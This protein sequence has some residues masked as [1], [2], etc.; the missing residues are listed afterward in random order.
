M[1]G[2]TN[3]QPRR[4]KMTTVKM[5]LCLLT[6]A[7][8]SAVA[9]AINQDSGIA[10][11]QFFA[12]NPPDLL[13]VIN[14]PASLKSVPVP[15]PRNLARYI[16]D[17][18]AAIAL[19]KALFWDM[20][21]GSDGQA[22]GSCHFHAFADSRSK[23]QL[24]PGFRAVP[25]DNTFSKFG[26][27][28]GGPN[29]Q[30]K[31]S[32]YPFHRLADPNNQDSVVLFDTNDITS[33]A[34]VFNFAF[35]GIAP[36]NTVGNETDQGTIASPDPVFNVNG[37]NVR[38]VEP[39]NTPT[40]INAVFN[41]RNFWDGRARAEFNGQTPIGQ[42]DPAVKV[43]HVPAPGAQPEMVSLIDDSHRDLALD[44][45]SLASQAVGPPL[46]NLEMSYNN[47]TFPLLGRKMM[48]RRPL[49]QQLVARDDSAL[50]P[51]SRW[52]LQGL[53]TTYRDMIAA[54][55]QNEWWDSAWMVQINPDNSV[56]FLPSGTVSASALNNTSASA[57]QFQL[58]EYNFSLI[59]G[60]ALQEYMA[61]LVSDDSRVDRF[62][63]GHLD[64][65]TAQEKLGLDVFMFKGRCI[66]CHG[67][68]ETTNASVSNI[69]DGRI[70]PAELLEPMFMGDGNFAVYDNGFYNTGTRPCAGLQPNGQEGPCAD[71][72]VG[73][74]IGPLNLPLSNAR[75]QQN[76]NS[77]VTHIVIVG[78]NERIVAD[79]AFKTPGL[80]NVELT[81]PYFHN[82]GML[83]LEQV[84]EFYNRGGD[85]ARFNINNLDLDITSLNL[86][87]DEKVALVAFLKALTDERVRYE[88]APFD[89]PELFVSNGAIGDNTRVIN[90]GTG[91]AVMDTLHVTAVGRGGRTVAD[92]NFL[93]T[94]PV[95]PALGASPA[96]L[97]FT[98]FANATTNPAGQV[99]NIT[100]LGEGQL[101]WTLS[102][103]QPWLSFSRTSGVAPASPAQDPTLSVNISG[104]G[105]G[106]YTDTV[107]ITAP[108]IKNSP[109]QVTVTLVVKRVLFASRKGNPSSFA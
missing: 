8:L 101:S 79:G 103:T 83:T 96:T 109:M 102:A 41:H 2:T 12:P 61:T 32:D 99:L 94:P 22:C 40:V 14:P 59:W 29:Y 35:T 15:E 66:R 39:R 106:T 17:R 64:A 58:I 107:T 42:L 105:P 6:V 89:H 57:N 72:G 27:N 69:V 108:G 75:L 36:L 92:T 50:G 48:S 53:N 80:R 95:P 37:I 85:F 34:G 28:G 84:V 74:S 91:K 45:A 23:S 63:E 38:Q 46:S 90:D 82:G 47:R 76:P 9:I 54:A 67:G 49:S 1:K 5:A 13:H 11:A 86:T 18:N 20:A 55:F 56:T 26:Q 104:L 60:L 44:N 30:L 24:N 93:H 4:I 16:K 52:P 33:S 3:S 43:A 78:P 97:T 68:A 98:A 51:P 100:N 10:K 81:A 65:L 70:S 31:V 21:V 25:P 62:L 77:P 7:V 87:A 19:G 88:Q 71:L 73:A